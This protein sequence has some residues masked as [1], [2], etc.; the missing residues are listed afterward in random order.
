MEAKNPKKVAKK[1]ILINWKPIAKYVSAIST[2]ITITILWSTVPN[3]KLVFTSIVMD[4]KLYPRVH[5]T[6]KLVRV[7]FYL[8]EAKR[9]ALN[10]NFSQD[11]IN[12]IF[13]L[14]KAC[15]L[16]RCLTIIGT[17]LSVYS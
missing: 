17:I 8:K 12:V 16:R 15:L 3:A 10:C 5:F 7:F 13:A 9:R 4:C 14:L 6:A 1:L 11:S 2:T